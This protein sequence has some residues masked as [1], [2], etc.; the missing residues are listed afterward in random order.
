M[1]A[2]RKYLV[3]DNKSA[4]INNSV[5]LTIGQVII[6]A[7]TSSTS[8][9]ASGGGTTSYLLGVVM[10]FKDVNGLSL[11]QTTYTASASNLTGN[12]VRADYV[13]LDQSYEFTVD[14][15]AAANTT[16]G[17]GEFGNFAV[18]S[19]GLL[20]HEASYV[21]FGTRTS[22][23]MFSFGLTGDTSHPRQIATKFFASVGGAQS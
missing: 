1:F 11:E 8:C 9:V 2:P 17:S 19:T 23:Q 10:G 13:P 3:S 4:L 14:L 15:D 6:P 21:A 20:A 18:D 7:V 16:T 12:M 5:A 22:V